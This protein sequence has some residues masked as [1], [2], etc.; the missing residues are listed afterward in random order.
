MA[1]RPILAVPALML[2]T[3]TALAHGGPGTGNFPTGFAHPFSGADHLLAMAAVGLYAAGQQ[4]R[5]RWVLP[6]GFLLAMLAG[7]A[8]GAGGVALPLVEAGIA[9]SVLVLGLLIACLARLPLGVAMPMMV[10]FAL[11]HGHAHGA[12]MGQGALAAYAAG[13]TLATAL[14]HAS[15][16]LVA[17][18]LP[19]SALGRRTQRTLGVLIATSGAVL[20]GG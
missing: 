17:R 11:F 5:A 16:Y 9:A 18:W 1:F 8:L 4:G 12:E 3:G 14:L 10:L 15:G 13:F 20:L 6:G 2:L 7:A 19:R